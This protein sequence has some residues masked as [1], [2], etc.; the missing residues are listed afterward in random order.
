NLT[1]ETIIEFMN[2]PH[3]ENRLIEFE[4]LKKKLIIKADQGLIQRVIVNLLNNALIHTD[5]ETLIQ[6]RI[7]Q[8]SRYT[9]FTIE[10][11]GDGIHKNDLPHIFDR[12][13][14]GTNTDPKSGSGLGMAIVKEIIVAHGGEIVVESSKGNGT[15]ITFQLPLE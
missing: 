12:Y 5:V 1:R 13:F 4:C 7:K 9:V 14:R 3:Y 11:N 10:D 6:V 2:M 8:T 15:K